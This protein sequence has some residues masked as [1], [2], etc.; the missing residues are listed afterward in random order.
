MRKAAGVLLIVGGIASTVPLLMRVPG[1]WALAYVP[2]V[3]LI[4]GGGISALRRDAYWWAWAAALCLVAVGII[5]VFWEWEAMLIQARRLD[6]ATRVL[7]S[8]LTGGLF[9]GLPGLLALLFLAK[10]KGEFGS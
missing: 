10:R 5:L 7:Y 8:G 9:A 3:A 2:G 4:V 6:V 1:D